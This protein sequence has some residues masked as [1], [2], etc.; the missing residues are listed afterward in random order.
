MRVRLYEVRKVYEVRRD[1][2]MMKNEEDE[3]M[4]FGMEGRA[5][6]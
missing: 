4:R 3:V 5:R 6:K 1:R 2:K